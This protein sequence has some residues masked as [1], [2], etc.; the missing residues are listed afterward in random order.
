L[1]DDWLQALA[2]I[3]G[4]MALRSDGVPRQ[5]KKGGLLWTVFNFDGIE[6]DIHCCDTAH[7]GKTLL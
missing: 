2:C 7:E 3:A 5:G 6:D 4:C 1:R